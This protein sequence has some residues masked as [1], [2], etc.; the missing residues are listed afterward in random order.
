MDAE[1]AWKRMKLIEKELENLRFK[2]EP[3]WSSEKSHDMVM[4]EFIQ[5]QY[6][7]PITFLQTDENESNSSSHIA[8][9]QTY[10]SEKWLEKRTKCVLRAGNILTTTSS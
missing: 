6:V 4:N 3:L 8:G 7:S 2:I 10:N 1:I 9:R 5:K